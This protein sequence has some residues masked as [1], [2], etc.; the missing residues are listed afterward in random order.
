MAL[1][2][3]KGVKGSP[4]SVDYNASFIFDEKYTAGI[5]AR[6]FNTVG[7]QTLMLFGQVYRLGYLFEVLLDNSVGTRYTSHELMF[8]REPAGPCGTSFDDFQFL[9]VLP[10]VPDG[11]KSNSEK[12]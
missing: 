5:Y 1:L 3:L 11:E 2:L 8:R 9:N 12:P 6:N 4:L 7:L 10:A